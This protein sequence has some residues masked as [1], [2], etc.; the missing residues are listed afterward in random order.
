MSHLVTITGATG[1]VGRGIAER[2]LKNGHK[3]RAVGRDKAKLAP[4][5]SKGAE[6][7]VGDQ[8]NAKFLTEAFTGADAVFAMIPSSPTADDMRAEQRGF[9]ESIAEAIQNS[10]VKRVV[11][12]SSVG[13]QHDFGTGPITGLHELEESLKAFTNVS[14]VFLRPTYFMENFL[15]SIP[16]IRSGEFN[17]G[18]V[19]A[20][21][22]M[23]M[24]ATRDI[25]AVGAEYL[26]EPVFEG[27]I[28][29]ELLGPED[30]TF[31]E[32]TKILG[33]VIGKPDL[34]YVAF[35]KENY[36]N[37]LLEA[38]FSES[39]ADNYVEME[40]AMND[41][42]VASSGRTAESTTPTRLGDFARDTFAPAY[43]GSAAGA[44]T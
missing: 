12:L 36:R 15:H 5:V 1:H 23:P 14:A 13:A 18:L 33:S 22:K 24:I 25:A 29:R 43:K 44:G 16:M 41:G 7:R 19:H 10:G 26:A 27:Y 34:P 40:N 2:L 4:I 11:A 17:G 42:R 39:V 9:I 21:L 37:A 31:A 20:D 6:A 35:S 38:G 3:V 28:V 30:H 32:A 8:A